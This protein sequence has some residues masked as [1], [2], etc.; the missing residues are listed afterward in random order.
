MLR[1]ERVLKD[2]RLMLALTGVDPREFCDL[3]ESFD[4]LLYEAG[5]RHKRVRSFGGGRKGALRDGKMKLFYI[6]L[7]L[8]V[9]PTY[10]V[11]SFIFGVDRSRCCRWTQK[12]LPL[13]PQTL[14]RELVLPKRQIT[15]MADFLALG[16]G[17]KDLFLDGTE[18]P[19]QRPL[20]NQKKK[21]SGKKRVHTRKNSIISDE[22]RKILFVSPTKSGRV[23]DFTQLLKTTILKHLP[24]GVVLWGDKAFIGIQDY[25]RDDT[26]IIIPHKQPP[27]G[28][29]THQ[30]KQE[31]KVISGIRM[32]VEHA[33]GGMKRF[34][35]ASA[36]Y[37]NKKGQD[38]CFV[39]LAAGLWNFHLKI[40]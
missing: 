1:V 37:R 9:Y 25:I 2:R 23:H 30:Q 35:A 8:K 20:K 11:A 32:T 39:A 33:I 27:K 19:V 18:R 3:L 40:S 16:P 21:Y 6:L 4:R 12:L 29:L 10:D 31:N 28:R 26:S 15:S 5:H 38:D 22:Q 34:S 17:I 14:K 36:I 13:L 7:Y 24:S